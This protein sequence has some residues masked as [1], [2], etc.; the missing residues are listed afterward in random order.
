MAHFCLAVALHRM[1]RISHAVDALEIALCLNPNFVEAHQRI[2]YIYQNRLGDFEKAEE[3]QKI[4]R[5]IREAR[6]AKQADKRETASTI[7]DR[8]FLDAMV[9]DE[10]SDVENTAVVDIAESITVVSGLPRSG[11]SMIMQMLAAGGLEVL[12]DGVRMPDEDNPRGYFEL[13]AAKRLRQDHSWVS[14]SKG[15][16]VKIV[17]QLLP[18]LPPDLDYR[19]VFIDRELSEVL[20]SQRTMLTRNEREGAN[21]FDE[22][23]RSVFAQQLLKIRGWIRQQANIQVLFVKHTDVVSDPARAASKFNAF[24][25]CALDEAAMTSAVDHELYRQRRNQK[26][27]PL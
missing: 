14:K 1:G 24:L 13:E 20:A 11:T 9:Q 22:R 17:A 8:P 21:L 7:N 15:K 12:T 26:T 6:K 4:A 10:S 19:I 5:E 16:C 18:N 3:H 27:E 23:L 2:A 25:G